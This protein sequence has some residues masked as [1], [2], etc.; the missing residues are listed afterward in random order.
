MNATPA[1]KPGPAVLSVD[2]NEDKSCFA[3]STENG[4]SVW[5]SD[6]IKALCH[7][8]IGGIAHVSL[9]HRSSL[10]VLVGGG[11]DPFEPPN[12]AILWDDVT[13][14][15][16]GYIEFRLPILRVSRRKD[17][18]VV[19]TAV[20]VYTYRL[21]IVDGEL[22]DPPT[23]MHEAEAGDNTRGLFCV[24]CDP[25]T[26]LVR[27]VHPTTS[28]VGHVCVT[29][30]LAATISAAAPVSTSQPP[31][32]IEAHRHPLRDLA[33]GASGTRLATASAS[34][35]TIKVFDLDTGELLRVFR[36][37]L[38][39]CDIGSLCFNRAE[40]LVC[41]TFGT[42]L[43]VFKLGK[44]GGAGDKSKSYVAWV[45]E[46][47][48][49]PKIEGVPSTA[50]TRLPDRSSCVFLPDAASVLAVCIN[51]SAL[52]FRLMLPDNKL[53]MSEFHKLHRRDEQS[54]FL[55]MLDYA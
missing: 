33:L 37:Q 45:S 9:F 10:L 49:L 48:P 17:L 46:Y 24:H 50:Q 15:V 5:Q 41:G 38:L 7:R 4:F 12:K 19:A 3:L 42:V 54:D 27:L 44:Q 20:N 26:D 29:T 35:T 16:V 43:H 31:A 51:G 40:T 52:R 55:K 23:L 25:V 53:Q 34:G 21:A 28:G 39:S 18:M 47:V 11:K 14:R 2:W 1:S 6:P 36:A 8:D 32:L 13:C 22:R 30:I